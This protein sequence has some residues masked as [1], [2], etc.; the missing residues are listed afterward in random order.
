MND[1][2]IVLFYAAMWE[3]SAGGFTKEFMRYFLRGY[4]RENQL[5]PSW[6]KEIPYFLKLREIDLYALIHRSFDVE[7][8]DD[9]WCAGYMRGRKDFIEG[10]VP[11]I[12]FDFES[13]AEFVKP[14]ISILDPFSSY[15]KYN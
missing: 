2:A 1:I 8:L 10:N 9:P 11:Y 13:L 14:T 6:L 12:D 15:G 7:N 5:D 3:E 4:S